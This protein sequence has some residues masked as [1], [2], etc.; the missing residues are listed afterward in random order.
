MRP[1]STKKKSPLNI[2]KSKLPLPNLTDATV[3]TS[4]NG[5]PY[6]TIPLFNIH[7]IRREYYNLTSGPL[8]RKAV[9][10]TPP[11]KI[12]HSFIISLRIGLEFNIHFLLRIS[13]KVFHNFHHYQRFA[14]VKR[15]FHYLFYFKFLEVNLKINLD[16][17]NW[18]SI[19]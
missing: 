7:R 14:R 9:G 5:N 10:Y 4:F 1:P 18:I 16:E 15:N 2:F 19:K 12:V 8:Q 6:K 3:M 17:I 11:V 13:S